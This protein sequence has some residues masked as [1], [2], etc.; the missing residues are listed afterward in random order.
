LRGRKP[1][2]RHASAANPDATS[3]V[4]AADGPGRTST[5][6]PAAMAEVTRTY[7]GSLTS[8]IPASLT[9]ATTSPASMR[10]TSS[11]ARAR[12]LCSW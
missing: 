4:S 9:R 6:T 1:T 3:A 10:E 11:E 7:P 2:K 8:G 12:S 5:A